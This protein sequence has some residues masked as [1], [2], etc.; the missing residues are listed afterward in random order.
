MI[1]FWAASG[2][3]WAGLLIFAI[4]FVVPAFFWSIITDIVCHRFLQYFMIDRIHKRWIPR[5]FDERFLPHDYFRGPETSPHHLWWRTL[6]VVFMVFSLSSFTVSHVTIITPVTSLSKT[7]AFA[8]VGLLYLMVVAPLL[9]LVW[10]YYD[11]GLRGFDDTRQIAYPIGS[12]FVGYLTGLGTLG[13]FA[14]FLASLGGNDSSL[15]AYAAFLFL[16]LFTPC[17]VLTAYF[18]DSHEPQ[19][20]AK[21]S[22]SSVGRLITPKWLRA[23]EQPGA[24]SPQD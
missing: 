8:F 23:I 11:W 19:L 24:V 20:L 1:I 12:T 13:T 4:L 10:V 7:V 21:L 9:A 22:Q 6:Q 3:W 2:V 5:I 16:I 14:Q 15:A 18:H 17:L